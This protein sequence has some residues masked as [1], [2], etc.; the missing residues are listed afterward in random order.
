LGGRPKNP[1]EDGAM[2]TGDR[3]QHVVL[4]GQMGCGKSTVGPL[5]ADALGWPFRDNDVTLEAA[6]GETAAAIQASDGFDALHA[7]ERKVFEGLLAEPRSSVI[8]AAGSVVEGKGDRELM[9]R[10]AFVAWLRASPRTLAA[11]T[12]NSPR[13]PLPSPD[14]DAMFERLVAQ[15]DALYGEVADVVID[16]DD[17]VPH[18]VAQRV[19]DAL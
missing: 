18:E 16:T 15:R 6:T 7:L 14:R 2:A 1:R 10:R 9:K 3:P 12:A 17:L 11:R 8:A 13:R 5:V 19:L 4:V